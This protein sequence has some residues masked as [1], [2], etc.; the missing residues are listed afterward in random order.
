MT[1]APPLPERC[2]IAFKEWAGV[3][4]ALASG[5]QSIIFRKGGIAEGPRGFVPEHQAFWLYPTHVHEPQQGL[6]TATPVLGRTRAAPDRVGIRAIALV[7]DVCFLDRRE[8]LPRLEPF[9]IWTEATIRKRF[10]YR[11]PGLWV[12]AVRIFIAPTPTEIL[13]TPE[14]TGCKSWVPLDKPL[15]TAGVVPVLDDEAARAD[16]EQLRQTL[17]AG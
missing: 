2:A 4:D 15:A 17:N 5:R 8:L 6:R 3:C 12:L 13:I 14:H 16:L 9:H 7:Q 10:D 11:N 1:A